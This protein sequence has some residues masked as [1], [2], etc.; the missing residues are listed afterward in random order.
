M[1]SISSSVNFLIPYFQR[2]RRML[3]SQNL[4][5]PGYIS[6]KISDI[7]LW[8]FP[9][10]TRSLISLISTVDSAKAMI[11]AS[12]NS[13]LTA[14]DKVTHKKIETFRRFF[15]SLKFYLYY[16]QDISEVISNKLEIVI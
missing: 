6:F 2:K 14:S 12:N 11:Y 10:R 16:D 15:E 3:L 1:P 13:L 5:F 9:F 4:V 8:V 7:R